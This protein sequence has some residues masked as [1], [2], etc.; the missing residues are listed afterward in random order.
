MYSLLM[1]PLVIANT[2]LLVW[3]ARSGF[4]HRDWVLFVTLVLMIALPYDTAIVALGSTLGQG[5]LLQKLSAPRLNWFYLTAPLLL[6]IAGGIARRAGLA[7]AQANWVLGVLGLLAVGFVVN[8]AEKIFQAPT[9]YPACFEDL[10][11]YVSSVKPSQVCTPGQAGVDVGSAAGPGWC[12]ALLPAL[13][14]SAYPTRPSGHS[15]PFTATS[16]PWRALSGPRFTSRRWR[17]KQSSNDAVAG[18][19]GERCGDGNFVVM[20]RW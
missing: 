6:P 5:E 12:W 7:W 14:F 10:L 19:G 8:D 3:L 17:Q 2:L 1:L 15:V 20:C 11:R 4:R 16:C 18:L 9:I 13:Y